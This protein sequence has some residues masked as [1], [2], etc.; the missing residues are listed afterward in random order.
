MIAVKFQNGVP[1]PGYDRVKGQWVARPFSVVNPDDF[2]KINGEW[3]CEVVSQ[4]GGLRKIKVI[5]KAMYLMERLNQV[6]VDDQPVPFTLQVTTR[7]CRN[8]GDG[9]LNIPKYQVVFQATT[10]R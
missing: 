10:H 7:D 8:P 1:Q 9:Y 2:R 6:L 5:R 3:F 4:S